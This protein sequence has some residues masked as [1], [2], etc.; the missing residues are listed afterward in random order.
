[1]HVREV[2]HHLVG[3]GHLVEHLGDAVSE[4]EAVGGSQHGEGNQPQGYSEWA[5]K[6]YLRVA[7]GN[8]AE[9][10]L[11][12]RRKTIRILVGDD[13]V[14]I[15]EGRIAGHNASDLRRGSVRQPLDQ[16]DPVIGREPVGIS[17]R[18]DGLGAR[19]EEHGGDEQPP[20]HVISVRSR[21]DLEIAQEPRRDR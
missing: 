4:V 8:L 16:R 7:I 20:L 13:I 5:G 3:I 11:G 9:I 6:E 15:P 19:R 17:K 1:M 10:Q 14:R 12:L 2:R 21:G 18:R